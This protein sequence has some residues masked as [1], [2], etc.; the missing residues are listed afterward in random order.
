MASERRISAIRA[1]MCAA[2][3]GRTVA[4]L[5]AGGGIGQPLSM[6]LKLNPL[7]GDLRLYDVNNVQGVAAD[8]SHIETPAKVTGFTGSANIAAALTGVEVVV[9]PAGVPRK[10][11]MSRDDL[12]GIN[13]GIVKSLTESIAK[14]CP[15]AL[16]CIISNP[17]NSTVPIAAEVLKAA[18]VYD[19]KRLMGVT[20]LDIVRSNTFM[21]EVSHLDPRGVTVPVIGGHAGTTILP[22]L[23]QVT[24]PI[25]MTEP[26][27][28]AMTKKI[29]T[30]GTVVVEAKAGAGSATLSMAFAGAKFADFCIQGLNGT[31]VVTQAYVASNVTSLP[32]F[33]SSV[34][35]G[36]N[37]VESVHGLGALSALEEKGVAELLPVLKGQIEKGVAFVASSKK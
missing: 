34:T 16:I 11:G 20:T 1:H 8:L 24:P 3:A 2:A 27:C 35:L 25:P 10:P 17:V 37:G 36:V 6:L 28:V 30:A 23:S 26:A 22:L 12:F 15:M 21:G 7:V 9:I 32:F 29:Q 14:Y 13:A 5:G 4:V 18:G 33:A 31:P 19:P